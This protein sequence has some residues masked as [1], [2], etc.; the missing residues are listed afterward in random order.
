MPVVGEM[1]APHVMVF[2]VGSSLDFAAFRVPARCVFV[3]GVWGYQP[4]TSALTLLGELQTLFRYHLC[5]P[6]SD[7]PR[8]QQRDALRSEPLLGDLDQLLERDFAG[9]AKQLDRTCRLSQACP[10]SKVVNQSAATRP[11]VVR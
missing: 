3:D 11:Q 10:T 1:F 8:S 5:Q 2:R 4:E 6:L 7:F 9:I